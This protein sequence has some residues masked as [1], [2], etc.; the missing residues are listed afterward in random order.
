MI[1]KGE[2]KKIL[3]IWLCNTT[4]DVKNKSPTLKIK[5]GNN[6]VT[7]DSFHLVLDIDNNDYFYGS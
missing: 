3:L 2:F 4:N 7:F 5:F 6:L 1:F